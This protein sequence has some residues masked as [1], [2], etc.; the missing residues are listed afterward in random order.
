MSK[1]NGSLQRIINHYKDHDQIVQCTVT[2]KEIEALTKSKKITGESSI[3]NYI[4][5]RQKSGALVKR[6]ED[7]EE[8]SRD[9]K[10][11][12]AQM[13]NHPWL[14][15]FPVPDSVDSLRLFCRM[16]YSQ[17]MHS[18]SKKAKSYCTKVAK[19]IEQSQFEF[20]P[21]DSLETSGE[22]KKAFRRLDS[23]LKNPKTELVV[24]I[25]SKA[26]DPSSLASMKPWELN[27]R[28]YEEHDAKKQAE[29]A[30]KQNPED[31]PD[32]AFECLNCKRDTKK[33]EAGLTKKTAYYQMQTRSA[34]EPM[35]TFHSCLLCGNRWKS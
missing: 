21:F 34:D 30:R 17:H 28:P 11:K 31:I 18:N 9:K 24:R 16:R 25:V 23:Y 33:R 7:D 10:F 3:K 2:D 12:K 29:W 35:T 20:A 14:G 6:T 13:S 19:Q 1:A 32:G 4:K 15:T 8:E 27:P 22:Y 5:V 26:V